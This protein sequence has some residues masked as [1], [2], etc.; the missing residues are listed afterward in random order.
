VINGPANRD[1][2]PAEERRRHPRAA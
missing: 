2:A 1:L